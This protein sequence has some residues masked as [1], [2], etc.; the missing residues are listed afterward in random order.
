MHGHAW[1]GP[2]GVEL[3]KKWWVICC[4]ILGERVLYADYD[5][6]RNVLISAIHM[7]LLAKKTVFA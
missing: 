7:G 1:D 5:Y 6:I 3:D 4:Y 2:R